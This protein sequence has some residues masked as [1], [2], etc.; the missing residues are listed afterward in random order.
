MDFPISGKLS[1]LQDSIVILPFDVQ[2]RIPGL[3]NFILSVERK[4]HSD[5][6][7]HSYPIESL[8]DKQLTKIAN[9]WKV[10]LIAKA[11]ALRRA[12]QIQK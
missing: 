6:A 7:L 2:I 5:E 9:A 11:R 4:A 10:A 1:D 12:N 8:T 3:P